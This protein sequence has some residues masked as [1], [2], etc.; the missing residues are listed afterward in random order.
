M[1]PADKSLKKWPF[2]AFSGI[3]FAMKSTVNPIDHGPA[4]RGISAALSSARGG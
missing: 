1:H 4:R 2:A 3:I